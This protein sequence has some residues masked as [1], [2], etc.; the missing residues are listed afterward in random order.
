MSVKMRI[1]KGSVTTPRGFRA[2]AVACGIKK[3]GKNDLALIVSEREAAA[4][5]VFTTNYFA[6]AP[7][8]LTRK[9]IRAG[10]LHAVIINSGNANAC[11]GKKGEQNARKMM[12]WAAEFL[13]VS[14]N[15][16]AVCSTG[17]IGSQLPIKKIEKG[18]RSLRL[19]GTGGSLA[20]QAIMTTDTFKKEGAVRFNLGRI[21][22]S[23]GGIAKGA[24]MIQPNM[25]TMIAAITTDAAVAPKL[26]QIA[27]ASAANETFNNITVDGCEST[28]DTVIILA[29][30]LA[31]NKRIVKQDKQYRAFLHALKLLCKKLA[32]DIVRDGEGATK[33]LNVTV[34]RASSALAA[35]AFCRAVANSNLVKTAIYGKDPN[36]GR[37]VAALGAEKYPIKAQKVDIYFDNCRIVRKGVEVPSSQGKAAKILAKKEISLNIVINAGSHSHTV[38]S[39]DLTHD[40]ITINASYRS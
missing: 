27:L 14:P 7:V 21:K 32:R 13:G 29:N 39:C 2:G 9:N 12:F 3:N 22:A 40:Y 6:A 23:L 30:G 15:N 35:R 16:I 31:G 17:V 20:A 36:W 11:T 18:L 26:L 1:G 8:K 37:I 24:G 34:K 10:K 4:G 28:N 38:W 5:G 25:A 33:L 19:S